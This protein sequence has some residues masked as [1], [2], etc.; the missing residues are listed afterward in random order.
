MPENKR[1]SMT[2]DDAHSKKIAAGW[3]AVGL[4][5][6]GLGWIGAHKFMLGYQ[7]AGLISLLLSLLCV[8]MVIFNVLSLIEGI[9]YL[10]RSDEDFYQRY[11]LN[12]KNW[13]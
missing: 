7:S 13:L 6:I 1:K 10:T 3:T 8:P 4:S 5:L 9:I 12:E 2:L 11:I